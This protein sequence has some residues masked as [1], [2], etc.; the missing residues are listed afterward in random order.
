MSLLHV[1]DLSHIY[2]DK[3]LYES[4]SFDIF[5]GEHVGIVGQ[6]GVGKSTLIKI[7]TDEVI[8][9]KGIIKWGSN[10]KIGHL[11]QYAQI[12]KNQTI[13]D[14]LHDL[15]HNL[16]QLEKSLIK[17][18]EKLAINEDEKLLKKVSRIQEELIQSDF[19]QI[20]VK[21]NKVVFGLGINAIGVD[22]KISDISG[23]Q[24]A[25]VILAK[26]LLEEPDVLLLDEPTNFLDKEHVDWLISF[27]SSFQGTFLVVSH[28]IEFLDKITNTILDIDMKRI[29]KYHGRYSD[30]LN[31]KE[32]LREEYIKNY[33]VQQ[34][35]IE[36]AEKF[37]QKNIAGTKSKSAKSRRKQLD[38]MERLE[39]PTFNKTHQIHFKEIPFLGKK[40]LEIRNLTIGYDKP[41]INNLNLKLNNMEKVAIT[42]FNGIGKTTLLKTLVGEIPS[43]KGE[44]HF[45]P[46]IKIGYFEQDF[47]W[48]DK[49]K[50]PLQLISDYYPLL[51]QK[52]IRSLL[53]SVSLKESQ[54]VQSL[55]DLSG[56]EQ[57]KVKL[58]LLLQE[59][60][61]FL[62]LDEPTN[63]LDKE[64]K[65]ELQNALKIFEGNIILVSH[66]SNFYSG[67]IDR[68]VNI[69]DLL[70]K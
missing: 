34:K 48:E 53:A 1:E 2:L 26:L 9:D 16:Y 38:K 42:G 57:S 37:I 32:K 41:L 7:L 51:T 25:K 20:D 15:Y 39:P 55:E 30:F 47:V 68:V 46:Q 14:Y 65:R 19:Y 4:A 8:S 60:Y 54:V 66:E 6:N 17:I 43:L 10:I 56:G 12:D 22:K 13:S 45:H 23:G 33:K 50:T 44:Y 18:Y 27:L 67:W 69:E 52:Q 29:K 40:S 70:N 35:K 62:I 24:R 64:T 59:G 21:I 5:K 11:D 58:C 61:N 36:K 49:K 63:H 31:Q 28:D 3:T